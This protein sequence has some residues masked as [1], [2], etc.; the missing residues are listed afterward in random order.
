MKLNQKQY[1]DLYKKLPPEIFDLV[2]SG[3]TT[4]KLYEIAEKHHLHIDEA[5]TM[6]DIVMDTAMGVIATKNM[7]SELIKELSLNP[8]DASALVRDIN[9]QIFAPIK[10]TMIS[11]Y[12]H[13]NPFKPETLKHIDEVEQ[14]DNTHLKKE[15]LLAEIENPTEAHVRKDGPVRNPIEEVVVPKAE[16]EE[17]P[18]P[19]TEKAPQNN[20]ADELQKTRERML[21]SITEEKLSEIVAMKH[22]VPEEEKEVSVTPKI[23]PE[24]PKVV[25]AP[26]QSSLS[27]MKTRLES[28]VDGNAPAK[29]PEKSVITAVNEPVKVTSVPEVAEVVPKVTKPA[30]DP[31]R[32]PLS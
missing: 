27:D 12:Q 11:L 17:A 9:E 19:V 28:I 15:D 25:T 32:E 3:E 18:A 1:S 20:L 4:K 26:A 23:E 10:Q 30:V 14:E 21:S 24:V 29:L 6:H 22:F 2:T 16:P 13:S 5:G 31:Y 7:E 8:L